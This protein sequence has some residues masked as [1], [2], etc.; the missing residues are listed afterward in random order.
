[1]IHSSKLPKCILKH[2]FYLYIQRINFQKYKKPEKDL[3]NLANSEV[4][5]LIHDMDAKSTQRISDRATKILSIKDVAHYV[6][7]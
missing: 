4:Y 5:K 6:E 2:K 1:M 7:I 3:S